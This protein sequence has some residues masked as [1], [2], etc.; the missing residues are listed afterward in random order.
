LKNRLF[1]LLPVFLIIAEYTSFRQL[2]THENA[3]KTEPGHK[4]FAL[5]EM[6]TSEGCSSCPP[7][8]DVADDIIESRKHK[9]VYLLDFHVDYFNNMGWIDPFSRKAFTERQKMYG[10]IFPEAGLYTPQV[11]IN[12]NEEMLGSDAG[13][14][15]FAV[16]SALKNT[17][18]SFI[19]ISDIKNTGK[20][21]FLVKFNTKNLPE[22]ADVNIVLVQKEVVSK[23]IRGEN[24]GKILTHHNIVRWM[25]SLSSNETSAMIEPS[26]IAGASLSEFSII[27]FVQDPSTLKILAADK[28]DL[29]N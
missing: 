8:Y 26:Q 20:D 28:K 3:A 22:R 27:V 15:S 17:Q 13:K 12:G 23:V 5:M 16:N 6:F 9:N 10:R 4:H 21:S 7:A 19:Y 29:T 18:N 1:I 11:I 14:V 25:K 24:A 2:S